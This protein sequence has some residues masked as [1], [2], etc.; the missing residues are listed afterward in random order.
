MATEEKEKEKKPA[1]KPKAGKK[2]G[3]KGKKAAADGEAGT[4]APKRQKAA[5][6]KAAKQGEFL[7][8]RSTSCTKA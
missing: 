2:G 7:L 6:A 4:P 3:E 5:E 8:E 1:G